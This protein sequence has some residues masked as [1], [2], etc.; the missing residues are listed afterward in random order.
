MLIGIFMGFLSAI[1]LV[2][3]MARLDIRKFMGYPVI[4]D[5]TGSALF[6]LLFAG[7]LTGMMVAVIAGLTLSAIVWMI[8]YVIGFERFNFKSR[9]WSYYPPRYMAA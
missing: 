3:I 4:V 9:T 7:T 5:I 1:A 2:V 8:R 6:C